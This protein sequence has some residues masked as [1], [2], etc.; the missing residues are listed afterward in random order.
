[1]IALA[2][3]YL[4]EVPGVFDGV[5]VRR[6]LGTIAD[7]ERLQVHIHHVSGREI[8]VVGGGKAMRGEPCGTDNVSPVG[9]GQA[10]ERGDGGA[11]GAHVV[12]HQDPGG[13]SQRGAEQVGWPAIRANRRQMQGSGDPASQGRCET[14]SG[15]GGRQDRIGSPGVDGGPDPSADLVQIRRIGSHRTEGKKHVVCAAPTAGGNARPGGHLGY[16]GVSRP[17]QGRR[18]A[19]G[20][21]S[22][23][24]VPLRE[25]WSWATR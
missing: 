11:G 10:S 23:A 1:M 3:R 9:T 17:G 12:H 24:R 18:G 15:R 5:D 16:R 19:A 22:R 13:R 6:A 7:R 14:D 20:T 25:P 2:A 21:R 8:E 4:V